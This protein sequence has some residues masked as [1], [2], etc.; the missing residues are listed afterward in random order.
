MAEETRNVPFT[1]IQAAELLDLIEFYVDDMVDYR[2]HA[3]PEELP[4]IEAEIAK[5]QLLDQAIRA[6]WPDKE[7]TDEAR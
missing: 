7:P 5:A 2:K 6:V 3:D 1:A 4:G